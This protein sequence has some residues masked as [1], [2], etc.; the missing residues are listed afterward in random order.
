[1]AMVFG[2][3]RFLGDIR[4]HRE[5]FRQF[6]GIAFIVLVSIAGQPWLSLYVAGLVLVLVGV[7][8]RLWAS[9]H[10]KKN[11]ILATGGPYAYVRH[12][13]YVGNLF[14]LSGFA[15]ASSLWWSLPLLFAFLLAFYPPAIRHED[16]NLRRKFAQQWESWR[17]ETRALIPRLSPYPNRER[18]GWSFNQSLRQNGEPIFA[19]FFFS[20]LYLLYHWKLS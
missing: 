4:Y 2:L 8:I 10:V 6:F 9:G 14:L 5:R 7:A 16:E 3:R 11:K 17:R 20:C 1:M 18:D 13:L 12:P 15:V 19:L